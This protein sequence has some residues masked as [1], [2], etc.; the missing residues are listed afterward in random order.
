MAADFY[1]FLRTGPSDFNAVFVVMQ[2]KVV[3]YL[4]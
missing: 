3:V 2:P 4:Q 1:Q